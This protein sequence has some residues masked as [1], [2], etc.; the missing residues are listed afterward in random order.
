MVKKEYKGSILVSSDRELRK[1]AEPYVNTLFY[2]EEFADRIFMT[3]FI[4][5][6]LNSD[7]TPIQNQKIDTKKKGNPRRLSKRERHR[8]KFL[9]KL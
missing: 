5:N 7:E 3:N 8:N 2:S 1:N 4:E 6:E 9:R